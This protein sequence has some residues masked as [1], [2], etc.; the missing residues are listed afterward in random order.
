MDYVLRQTQISMNESDGIDTGAFFQPSAEHA[1]KEVLQQTVDESGNVYNIMA[2]PLPPPNGD[3]HVNDDDEMLQF[4]QGYDDKRP[5]LHK[6]EVEH[7]GEE[8]REDLMYGTGGR[9]H[10]LNEGAK[11]NRIREM[12]A[13]STYHTREMSTVTQ[14]PEAPAN[15]VG[16]Q[17]QVE[18]TDI[19]RPL[20]ATKRNKEGDA[21]PSRGRLAA[22]DHREIMESGEI[23]VADIG[24][25]DNFAAPPVAIRQLAVPQG[26]SAPEIFLGQ[27]DSHSNAASVGMSRLADHNPRGPDA[28]VASRRLPSRSF[29]APSAST[30]PTTQGMET[31]S[32][33]VTTKLPLPAPGAR[34]NSVFHSAQGGLK[35]QSLAL[36]RKVQLA[37]DTPRSDLGATDAL[38]PGSAGRPQRPPE[39]SAPRGHDS[40][41]PVGVQQSAKRPMVR[42]VVAG[43]TELA[44]PLQTGGMD[45]SKPAERPVVRQAVAGIT[46]LALPFQTGGMDTSKSAERPAVAVVANSTAEQ[47]GVATGAQ[48]HDFL[49]GAVATD[50]VERRDRFAGIAQS[51]RALG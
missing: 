29:G 9:R 5:R 15:F 49:R 20:P 48:A 42:Q 10:R 19:T 36:P 47:G 28:H 44:L 17:N 40:G 30:V 41:A 24:D 13:D 8:V 14:H 38:A 7:L 46:E 26:A 4:R 32:F 33:K 27:S 1:P 21:V 6:K 22:Q 12:A 18:Y 35:V 16:H 50:V 2:E 31:G 25:R 39:R 45:T 11:T 23:Q 3:F 43:I 37:Q 51:D 34:T